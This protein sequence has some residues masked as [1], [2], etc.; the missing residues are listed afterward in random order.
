VFLQRLPGRSLSS[1]IFNLHRRPSSEKQL[2]P[3]LS[4]DDIVSI[5]ID[6]RSLNWYRLCAGFRRQRPTTYITDQLLGSIPRQPDLLPSGAPHPRLNTCDSLVASP[7][8]R[9]VSES[10]VSDPRPSSIAQNDRRNHRLGHTDAHVAHGVA[11]PRRRPDA[12]HLPDTQ[13]EAQA[14]AAGE[15]TSGAG[16]LRFLL[17]YVLQCLRFW[18]PY[19]ADG[20]YASHHLPPPPHVRDGV[21]LCPVQHRL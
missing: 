6:S 19:L 18:L 8:V 16:C 5:S 14:D 7:A 9:E 17:S 13:A 4:T 1:S 10:L 21:R 11:H 12:L 15:D 2:R 20:H 3:P